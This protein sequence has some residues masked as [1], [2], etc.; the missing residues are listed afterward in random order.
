METGV[1]SDRGKRSGQINWHV[2]RFNETIVMRVADGIDAE[3]P[4]TRKSEALAGGRRGARKTKCTH[5]DGIKNVNGLDQRQSLV[6]ALF[7]NPKVDLVVWG[8]IVC[9]K[10]IIRRRRTNQLG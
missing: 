5:D 4:S 7:V 2:I 6:K 10:S 3:S 1:K 8:T 9:G